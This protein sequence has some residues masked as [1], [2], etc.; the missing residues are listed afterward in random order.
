[1]HHHRASS[2]GVYLYTL[3]MPPAR[4]RLEYH[5]EVYAS[6]LEQSR[7]SASMVSCEAACLLAASR[8]ALYMAP[9]RMQQNTPRSTLPV[10]T[11]GVLGKARRSSKQ[12]KTN[13]RRGKH[14]MMPQVGGELLTVRN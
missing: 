6:N 10:R 2:A 1:V 11:L 14:G 8:I 5:H 4:L 9:A 7:R 3:H 13:Q 12:R